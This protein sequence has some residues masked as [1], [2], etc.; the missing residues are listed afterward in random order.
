VGINKERL[1]YSLDIS[2]NVNINTPI[3]SSISLTA[4]GIIQA[5]GFYATSDYRIKE[6]SIRLDENPDPEHYTIDNLQP[7]L[8]QNKLTKQ[9]NLGLIAHEVQQ[10]FPF[11][12]LGDKDDPFTYQSINYIGLIPLLIHEMKKLKEECLQQEKELKCVTSKNNNI[13]E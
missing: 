3:S 13:H 8:Y 1:Q 5:Q 9:T 2:G 10:L 12:V 11:L 7:Y 6:K 4:N